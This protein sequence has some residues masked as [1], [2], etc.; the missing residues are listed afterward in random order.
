MGRLSLGAWELGM[1]G[2][3]ESAAECIVIAVQYFIKNILTAV[4]IQ[5]SGYKVK[6]KKKFIHSIGAPVANPWLRPQLPHKRS[7]DERCVS[8]NR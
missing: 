7:P 1:A 6:N 3:E 2:A 5:R 4:L 8:I